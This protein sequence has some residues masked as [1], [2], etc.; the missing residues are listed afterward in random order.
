MPQ[1]GW[2]VAKKDVVGNIL[3]VQSG[4]EEAYL[5]SDASFLTDLNWIGPKP[6]EK[7]EVMVKFRY[8]DKDHSCAMLLENGGAS[9]LHH[10]PVKA[11]TPGQWAAIYSSEGVLL[12]GGI[13]D[14]TYRNGK[15]TDL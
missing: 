8:R 5:F 4:D 9:L 3:Y 10:E 6:Y 13:I 12:G 15:R 2:F 1:E 14:K 7:K 11:V